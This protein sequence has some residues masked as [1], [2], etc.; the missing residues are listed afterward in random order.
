[1]SGLGRCPPAIFLS[2]FFS[3]IKGDFKGPCGICRQVYAEVIIITFNL[4]NPIALVKYTLSAIGLG[5]T[6]QLTN[7]RV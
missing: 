1:M 2:Y 4:L 6:K 7:S 3:D 5:W